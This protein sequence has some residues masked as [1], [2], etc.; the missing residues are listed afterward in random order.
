MKRRDFLSTSAAG[1]VGLGAGS[2][3][4][5]FPLE[6]APEGTLPADPAGPGEA[7]DSA[8][9]RVPRILLAGGGFGTSFIGY[10][11]ELTEKPRP[12]I[13][14]LPTATA[15]RVE[16]IMRWY[17]MCAPLDIEPHYQ[18]SFV[19]SYRMERSWE[20]VFLSM[21]GIVVSGGN[22]LNQQAIWR[23]QGIDEVLREAWNRGIVLGGASAGSLC[24]FEEGTT[25]S[26]PQRVTKMECLGFLPGS[27][28]PHYDAEEVRRPTYQRMIASGELKPGWAC[29]NDAGILFE[30]TE[31]RRFVATRE[32]AM[33]YY[34]RMEGS[35]VVE[36]LHVPELI[37]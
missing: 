10:M 31:P 2:L 7:S 20:E 6:G 36:D 19:S 15:D 34:V 22:T 27:H 11:A 23:A 1:M 5:P 30:G 17:E 13:C 18:E 29:D 32:G 4:A 33:V 25:D 28:S 14:F 26:R 3:A 9:N 24:W 16:R 35:Q 21:D 8:R 12:R 37:G